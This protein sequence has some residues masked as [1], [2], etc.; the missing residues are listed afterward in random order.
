MLGCQLSE[1][2]KGDFNEVFIEFLKISNK[3]VQFCRRHI[4][5]DI[6][7]LLDS[8]ARKKLQQEAAKRITQIIIW[9]WKCHLSSV[10][11]KS[12]R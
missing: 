1:D 10:N 11:V 5:E 3:F 4:E 6:L 2:E 8:K 7:T 12:K 9:N